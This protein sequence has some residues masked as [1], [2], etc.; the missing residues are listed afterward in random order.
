MPDTDESP[1]IRPRYKLF[2]SPRQRRSLIEHARATPPYFSA[3]VTHTHQAFEPVTA[4]RAAGA[5]S[6]YIYR[7]LLRPAQPAHRK[8]RLIIRSAWRRRTRECISLEYRPKPLHRTPRAIAAAHRRHT[9]YAT[10]SFYQYTASNDRIRDYRR[11]LI[12][13]EVTIRYSA[14]RRPRA[15][16]PIGSSSALPITLQQRR[17]TPRRLGSLLNS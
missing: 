16:S 5:I 15:P 7:I 9:R 14:A 6:R 10:H 11:L 12:Y 1:S 2:S 17:I 3:A 4:R 8:Q 13:K